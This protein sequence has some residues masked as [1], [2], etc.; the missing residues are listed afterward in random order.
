[1]PKREKAIVSSL[2]EWWF[3]VDS[4]AMMASDGLG[5]DLMIEP[6]ERRRYR[7]EELLAQC[8]ATLPTEEER[9]WLELCPAGAELSGD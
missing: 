9:E 5:E 6:R 3:N 7:L 8:D 2:A 1:L 4:E